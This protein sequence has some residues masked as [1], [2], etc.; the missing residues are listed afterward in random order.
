METY[1]KGIIEKFAPELVYRYEKAFYDG[2]TSSYM[3][4]LNAAINSGNDKMA[5][6]IIDEF[7]KDEKIPVSNKALRTEYKV[8]YAEGYSVFPKTVG[9]TITHNGE[10]INLTKAQKKQ[11]KAIYSEANDKLSELIKSAIY[12]TSDYAV[13]AKTIK[14]VY[15]YYYNLALEDLL[16]EQTMTDKQRLFFAAFGVTDTIV[17][18][19]GA[20]ALT[21]DKDKKGNTING[22]RKTK[23]QKYVS[24]LKL[25]AAQKYILMGYLGYKNTLGEFK[26]K[27]YI[28]SL[29]L[30][31]ADKKLLLQYS[32]YDVK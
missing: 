5:D 28:Q 8:L 29:K 9:D 15:D 16:G 18:Y 14:N 4:E 6:A 12:Q 2:T 21:S 22:S 30:S 10:N 3:A 20:Q 7:M 17:G 24:G 19:Y 11:F 23:V 27:S 26:V 25:N 32:G 31:R 13:R 1:T